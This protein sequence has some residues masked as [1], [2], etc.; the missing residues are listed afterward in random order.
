M[1]FPSLWGDII[2]IVSLLIIITT[3]TTSS[4]GNILAIIYE[5]LLCLSL[6]LKITKPGCKFNFPEIAVKRVSHD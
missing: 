3:I 2:T 4:V 5:Y 1:P 6:I